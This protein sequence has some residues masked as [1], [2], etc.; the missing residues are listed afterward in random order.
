MTA[1]LTWLEV[2][3]LSITHRGLIKVFIYLSKLLKRTIY[4]HEVGI[5]SFTSS[6]HYEFI[7]YRREPCSRPINSSVITPALVFVNNSSYR[8]TALILIFHGSKTTIFFP[9]KNHIIRLFS[10]R[11]LVDMYYINKRYYTRFGGVIILKKRGLVEL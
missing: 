4:L 10:M 3:T 8:F 1:R 11:Y 9:H 5:I 2:I 6:T 7:L